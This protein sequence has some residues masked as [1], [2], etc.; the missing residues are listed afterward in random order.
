M[1]NPPSPSRL[2]GLS[3]VIVLVALTV[4]NAPYFATTIVLKSKA[5]PYS[6]APDLSLYLNLS[7]MGSSH[8]NPYFGTISPSGELGYTTFDTAFRMLGVLAKI[9][10]NDLWW[11]VLLWDLF[12]WGALC[13]GAIWF[14]RRALPEATELILC[15]A[16]SLILFF[17]FGVL[18]AL[19]SAWLHFPSMSG[20]AELSLPFIRVI[21]PQV[22]L[23]LMFFYLALQT[24]AL[25]SW[26]WREW[27]GMFFLQAIAFAMF[28]YA[29]LIMAGTTCVAALAVLVEKRTL[30]RFLILAT[31]GVACG[32]FDVAFLLLHLSGGAQHA[33][34]GLIS[35][36]PSR[37][38]E[39][40][41]GALL[42]LVVLTIATAISPPVGSRTGK[43]TVAGLGIANI[44][45]MLGDSVFSPALLVSHHGGYF[46]HTTISLETTYLVAVAFDRFPRKSMWLRRA[47]LA[48][49]A[50]ATAT[51]LL[52]AF[53]DYRHSF[54]ENSKN[55]ELAS[56]MRSLNLTKG[57]LVI[58]RA[59]SVDDS[60]SW[61]PLFTD[62]NTLF[63]RSAQ[64]EMSAE[65]KRTL[66]RMRQA[67]YLYF[68]GDSS[69]A[70]D[71][72]ASGSTNLV[73]QDRLAFAG[74]VNPADRERWDEAR[75]AIRSDLV[76]V[77]A[78]VEQRKPQVQTL[79]STYRRILVVDDA[80]KP[81]FVRK[82]LSQYLAID[83]ESRFGDVVLLWCRPL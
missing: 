16:M 4:Y 58:A 79:L 67:F 81:A 3:F 61:V 45:L 19:A 78:D 48:A 20:F 40:A 63:C 47:C 23:A 64:Y 56:A 36:H 74:E 10:G 73:D 17:N 76:P 65:Q 80:R 68:V 55:L 26:H 28:P 37:A 77:L 52:L 30:N 29:T 9:A 14:I 1:G 12:W 82:S 53:S 8:V 69:V 50:L 33:K 22:P 7:R 13:V 46:I 71:Q 49:I 35:I 44:L 39:L 5:I 60:C 59:E 38:F 51:G 42:L 24:R 72:V 25:D 70:V 62:A 57:D 83:S 54:P 21:F 41:G 15:L 11:A 6:L 34:L 32:I 27:T 75:A 66:Y 31:Y 2:I 18:K 43:W